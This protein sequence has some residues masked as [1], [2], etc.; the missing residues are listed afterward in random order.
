MAENFPVEIGVAAAEWYLVSN[1]QTHESPLSGA[2]QTLELPGARWAAT[3]T[4]SKK[5]AEQARPLA[6]FLISLR[7]QAGNFYLHDHTHPTPRG[8]A[9]GTPVVYGASQTGSQLITSGW[10]VNV[11]DILLA[12]DYIQV[13]NELKMVVADADSDANGRATLQ[14]EPPWR[15]SPTD[16]AAIITDHPRAL[17]K[18]TDNKQGLKSQP[19]PFSS[20]TITCVEDLS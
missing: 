9:A 14:I 12:G 6:A 15:N 20:T 11:P 10:N 18:L 7:G 13:G 2:M 3:L 16:A 17:M 19:G 5:K 4:I 1:T 8:A